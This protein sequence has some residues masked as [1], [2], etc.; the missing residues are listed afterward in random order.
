MVWVTKS[1]RLVGRL[2]AFDALGDPGGEEYAWTGL[3]DGERSSTKK[4]YD[5]SLE[6]QS[7]LVTISFSFPV[8]QAN[9]KGSKISLGFS[10]VVPDSTSCSAFATASRSDGNRLASREAEIVLRVGVM[11]RRGGNGRE[12]LPLTL[13]FKV[14]V[15]LVIDVR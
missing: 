15:L 3:V 14:L 11:S 5:T 2:P 13:V 9:L 6:I 7:K 12:L 4:A 1:A 10:A 8:S